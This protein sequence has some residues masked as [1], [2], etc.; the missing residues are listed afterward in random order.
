MMFK[1][2]IAVLSQMNSYLMLKYMDCTFSYY[3]DVKVWIT[4]LRVTI[5][6]KYFSL[7]CSTN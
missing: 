6:L 3:C 5:R 1:E 4:C 2:I 7:E